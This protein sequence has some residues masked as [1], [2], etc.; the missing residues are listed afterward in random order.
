MKHDE[1]VAERLL[2]HDELRV[3]ERVFDEILRAGMRNRCLDCT[4]AVSLLAAQRQALWREVLLCRLYVVDVVPQEMAEVLCSAAFCAWTAGEWRV[5]AIADFYEEI[6]QVLLRLFIQCHCITN[7]L[8][9][10][11]HESVYKPSSRK[12]P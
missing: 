10:L 6:I 9:V 5:I 2:V 8:S 11:L 4:V 12:M 7:A 3:P 1:V